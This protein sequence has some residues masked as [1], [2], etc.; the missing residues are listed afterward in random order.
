MNAQVVR[1]IVLA[2]VAQPAQ[3]SKPRRRLGTLK[4]MEGG[5]A[6]ERPQVRLPSGVIRAVESVRQIPHMNLV[7][8]RTVADLSDGGKSRT[9]RVPLNTPIVG[10]MRMPVV[11]E[12][13]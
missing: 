10:F 8:I 13:K 11:G 4:D 2:P 1:H 7:E 3:S 6:L 12:S 9:L 5:E